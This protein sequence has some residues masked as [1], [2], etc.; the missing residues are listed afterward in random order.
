MTRPVQG[1][2]VLAYSD[3]DAASPLSSYLLFKTK[4][5]KQE[6]SRAQAT[7]CLQSSLYIDGCDDEQVFVLQYDATNIAPGQAQIGPA[8]IPLPQAR[9]DHVS[10]EGNPQ[11]RTLS[12]TLKRACPVWCRRSCAPRK[13][14]PGEETTFHQLGKLA[15]ATKLH[16]LFDLNQ[17]HSDR[18]SMLKR[19]IEHPESFED[20]PVGQHYRERSLECVDWSVLDAKTADADANANDDTETEDEAWLPVYAKNYEPRDPATPSPAPPY[21][22]AILSPRFSPLAELSPR[23]SHSPVATSLS[24]AVRDAIERTV[25][26]VLPDMIDSRLPSLLKELV[27]TSPLTP[28][29][30]ES[31]ASRMSLSPPL[32]VLSE[33]GVLVSRD[34]MVRIKGDLDRIYEHTL[35]HANDLHSEA[36]ATFF[37]RLELETLE[38]DREAEERIGVFTE[39]CDAEVERAEQELDE[40]GNDALRQETEQ[41]EG[42]QRENMRLKRIIRGLERDKADLRKDKAVLRTEKKL[43]SMRQSMRQKKRQQKRQTLLP[44]KITNKTSGSAALASRVGKRWL[45]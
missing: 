22:S 26:A 5:L 12:L 19:L 2:S 11:I 29:S 40:L 23:R 17:L 39:R 4:T 37:E 36:D 32:P 14:R 7:L 9:L 35:D 15:Q 6:K 41:K 25:E 18:Y 34:V 44:R 1:I 21:D 45:L 3:S 24:P 33:F 42:L 16:V 31:I 20:F 27:S 43:Q 30:Q 13:P 10:R 8:T 38:L 28:S